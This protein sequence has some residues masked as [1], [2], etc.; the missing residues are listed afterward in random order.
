LKPLADITTIT[1]DEFVDWGQKE[2]YQKEIGIG[3]CA[4]VVID[5]VATLLFETEE[6]FGWANESF[7]NQ[8]WADTIFHAYSVFIS[9]AKA[10]L[11]DKGVNGNSHVSIIDG[12]DE[13][14]VKT[15]EFPVRDSFSN[16][17]LQIKS[18]EPTQEFAAAY[19]K[20]AKEFYQAISRVRDLASITD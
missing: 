14:F 1:E 10:L 12:F 3:E 6:K 16:I 8:A 5:L 17:V 9:G 20:E 2:N 11:L 18:N 19:L 13:H 7:E 15:G 4:G